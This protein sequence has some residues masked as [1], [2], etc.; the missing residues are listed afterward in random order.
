MSVEYKNNH[1][2]KIYIQQQS[3]YNNLNKEQ[4]ENDGEI[5]VN[6][7]EQTYKQSTRFVPEGNCCDKHPHSHT[8][9]DRVSFG[10]E[11]AASRNSDAVRIAEERNNSNTEPISDANANILA[12]EE[13]RKI[14]HSIRN[15]G[16]YTII[17]KED[18]YIDNE[19]NLIIKD[20]QMIDELNEGFFIPT[21]KTTRNRTDTAPICLVKIY[22]ISGVRLD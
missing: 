14:M 1:H 18:E 19:C 3:L 11:A 20:E 13:Y 4:K 8:T 16:I 2:I 22:A 17:P 6:D 12:G 5:F 10:G 7:P 9:N 21:P 15:E